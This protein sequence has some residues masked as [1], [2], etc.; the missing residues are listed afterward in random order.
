MLLQEM[1][2]RLCIT[3]A[4]APAEALQFEVVPLIAVAPL[5]AVVPSIAG[6]GWFEGEQL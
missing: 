2:F 4:A 1:T 5:I 6:E 3:E